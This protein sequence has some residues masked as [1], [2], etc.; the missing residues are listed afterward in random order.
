MRSNVR[1]SLTV[2]AFVAIAAATVGQA[3]ADT[4]TWTNTGASAWATGTN[5]DLGAAPATADAVVLSNGGTATTSTTVTIG[6]LTSNDSGTINS[7][8]V[9][10]G[11]TTKNGNGSL[12]FNGTTASKFTGGLTVNAGTVNVSLWSSSAGT[13][14]IANGATLNM[15]F[16]SGTTTKTWGGTTAN[17]LAG[18]GI[19]NTNGLIRLN[20]NARSS[21]TGTTNVQS[22]VLFL[23]SGSSDAGLGGPLNIAAAARVE[24]N[25]GTPTTRNQTDSNNITCLG[26]LT[27]INA[28]IETLT[29]NNAYYGEIQVEGALVLGGTTQLDIANAGASAKF[30]QYLRTTP[31]EVLFVGDVAFNSAVKLDVADVTDETGSWTLVASGLTK[32]YGETFSVALASGAAF[33]ENDNVWTCTTGTQAWTFT[34]ATGTLNLSAVPEPSSIVLLTLGLL[35]FVGYMRRRS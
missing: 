21:F 24:L 17:L 8:L 34:E 15:S 14:T 27:K 22:G 23:G 5:W 18:E 16:V 26:T 13:T 29:G 28:G 6:S 3:S 20:S 25:T 19:L 7:A 9:V 33:V 32:T 30:V 12:T 4:H 11:L 31:P 35:G 2:L 10:T 1:I